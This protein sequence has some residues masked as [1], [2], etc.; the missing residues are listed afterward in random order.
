MLCCISFQMICS[1]ALEVTKF[2]SNV[3][4][5]CV[6]DFFCIECCM[7]IMYNVA[8]AFQRIS[9]RCQVVL[10]ACILIKRFSDKI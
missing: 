10:V 1:G 6:E 7:L 8:N 4:Q 2:S 3:V 9:C 5:D